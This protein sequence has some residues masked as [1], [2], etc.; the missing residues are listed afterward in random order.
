MKTVLS[1]SI[2]GAQEAMNK[3]LLLRK[4]HHN[5]RLPQPAQY[6]VSEC[7]SLTL[8]PTHIMF[9]S[10]DSAAVESRKAAIYIT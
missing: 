5:S 1:I 2:E 10:R 6:P 7:F 4:T 9:S 8:Q 3:L